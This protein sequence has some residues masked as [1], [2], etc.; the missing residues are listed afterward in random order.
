M[1]SNEHVETRS[2]HTRWLTILLMAA[3]SFRAAAGIGLQIYLDRQPDRRF[4]I[5]GDAN[6]Y[7]ELGRKIATGD[8]YAVHIPPRYVMRTPG[9]PLLLA[10]TGG[11][12]WFTRILLAIVG[13]LACGLVYLLA[14]EWTDERTGLIACAI[15]AL[16]PPL[17]GFSVLILSETLFAATMLGGLIAASRTLKFCANE[18]ETSRSIRWSLLT[19]MLI[20]MGSYVRP[21]W[22]LAGPLFAVLLVA[23]ASRRFKAI[24]Y[25]ALILT[26]MAKFA[27]DA[28]LSIGEHGDY[29]YTKFGQKMYPRK[30]F[31]D[32]IT[33]PMI[34]SNRFAPVFNDKHLSYR[35]D[36]AKEMYDTAKK[37]GIPFQAGSSVPLAQRIPPLSLPEDAE[38]DEAVSIHGGGF[39]VYDFHGLEVLQSFVESRK[40]GETGIAEIELLHGDSLKRA[41]GSG[42]ISQKL[43]DA[44]MKTET[45]ANF[46]RRPYPGRSRK[47]KQRG[48]TSNEKFSNID[49]PMSGIPEAAELSS[50]ESV[51]DH[52]TASDATA[53]SPSPAHASSFDPDSPGE[54]GTFRAS[55]GYEFAFRQFRPDAE[56]PRGYVVALHGIQ[57]HSGWYGYSSQQ[58][59]AAGFDV[60]FLDR[61]GS[62]LNE[63]NRGHAPHG[64]RLANDV[65]QFLS[66]VRH[67]RDQLASDAPIILLAVSWG[68]KLAA[69]VAGRRPHLVDALALLYP[70]ICP[71]IRPTAR[72]RIQLK[73][74]RALDIRH[75]VAPIPLDDPA[76]FTGVPHWQNA[77]RNDPLA[78][79]DATS[80]F[81]LASADLDEMVEQAAPSISCPTL[82]MLAGKDRIIDNDATW[83]VFR[84]FS[85]IDKTIFEYPEAAHTLEF[86]PDRDRI[87][88]DLAEW[89]TARRISAAK[90]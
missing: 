38:I 37:H 2:N 80:G 15:V 32:E 56:T 69:A 54:L 51:T 18:N 70:G 10:L 41:I 57:S 7:W 59:A 21:G 86:E 67:E 42:R 29:P 71:Q 26:G 13:T 85:S 39:E 5:E 82:L 60:R 45:N 52:S 87:F 12:F 25:G 78:L 20:A 81:F 50:A 84:R 47:K 89:M 11:S 53:S 27:V 61:R 66:H 16:S 8:D 63:T 83:N 55:D 76:L 22:I 3:F 65:A 19:G 4:L 24:G 72:Q 49:I 14:R 79:H 90:R 17:L 36:W 1:S 9:F 35:W 34:A 46:K 30:R 6:G 40:G 33:Q 77:I 43:I 23:F 28:V 73:L 48:A 75:K 44:A 74:A 58:L 31:F 62:G 88:A 68:G 64:E